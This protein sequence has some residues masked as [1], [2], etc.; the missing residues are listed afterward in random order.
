MEVNIMTI[1]KP[2]DVADR[3]GM[4][5][6]T[7]QTWDRKGILKAKRSPTNR[8]FYTEDQINQYLSKNSLA[9][10]KNKLLM[11]EYQLLVKKMT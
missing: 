1:L 9:Q 10:I 8:R 4:T 7:L 6:R 3:L 5:T 11:P 2:K